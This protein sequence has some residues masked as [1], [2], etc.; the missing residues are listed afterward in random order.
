MLSLFLFIT[1]LRLCISAVFSDV[2]CWLLDFTVSFWLVFVCFGLYHVRSCVP[3]LL[4]FLS[5]LHVLFLLF[6]Y[7]FFFFCFTYFWA[8]LPCCVHFPCG[9]V[10]YFASCFCIKT[11]P[12]LASFLRNVFPWSKHFSINGS[13]TGVKLADGSNLYVYQ[14]FFFKSI[15]SEKAAGL[16]LLIVWEQQTEVLKEHHHDTDNMKLILIWIIYQQPENVS[17]DFIKVA[18]CAGGCIMYASSQLMVQR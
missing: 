17:L 3:L 10:A 15:F 1:L 7:Y 5:F 18:D 9:R 12:A 14:S 11:G 13:C 2:G 6:I 8:P 16:S 4:H